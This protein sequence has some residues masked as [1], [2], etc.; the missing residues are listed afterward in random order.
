MTVKI[1]TKWLAAMCSLSNRES[2][3][4]IRPI[5]DSACNPA[6]LRKFTND[7]S[8]P[9]AQ[10]KAISAIL[11]R[12]EQLSQEPCFALGARSNLFESIAVGCRVVKL[13]L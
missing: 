3:K 4:T 11:A 12:G 5:V 9:A 2:F 10:F 13:F 6:H 1:T 8:V 7:H